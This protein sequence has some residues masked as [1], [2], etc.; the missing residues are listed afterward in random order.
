METLKYI[1]EK[2][3]LPIAIIVVALWI[4]SK[5]AEKC[6]C[7]SSNANQNGNAPEATVNADGTVS[8]N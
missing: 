5:I 1:G 7:K 3:L 6:D 4:F 8:T 2:I